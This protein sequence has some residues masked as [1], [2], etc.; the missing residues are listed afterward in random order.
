MALIEAFGEVAAFTFDTCEAITST[1]TTVEGM[2]TTEIAE[3]LMF[4]TE[5]AAA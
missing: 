1:V 5:F 3:Q 4:A 2:V